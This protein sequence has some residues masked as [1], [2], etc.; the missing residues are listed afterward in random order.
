[1]KELLQQ[2]AAYNVWANQ[3]LLEAVLK[4]PEESWHREI[5]SSFPSLHTTVL[6]MWDAESIWWQRMKMQEVVTRPSDQFKGTTRDAITALQHQ[7]RLWQEWVNGTSP[8]MLDHVFQY[9]DTKRN[10]YKQPI[11]QMLHH[12][13]NHGTYHRGQIVTLLRQLGETK[14]PA[15]DFVVWTRLKK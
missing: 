8:A 4:L 1:M 6:H 7:N 12:V 9:Y 2:Y 5:A 13:M 15:T 10:H 11:Y 3:K 14:I